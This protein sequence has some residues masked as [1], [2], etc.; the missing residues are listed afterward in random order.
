[1]SQP[2]TSFGLSSP[3][4]EFNPVDRWKKLLS[5][6]DLEAVE[7]LIGDVLVELGYPLTAQLNRLSR[8]RLNL[9]LTRVL[10][11]LR[12]DVKHWAKTRTR[13][14]EIWH[15]EVPILAPSSATLEVSP[16]NSA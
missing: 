11:H 5:T 8:N 14:N 3:E 9:S 13:S 1:V 6:Q 4:R 15:R 16:K 12:F 2:N 7:A 10:Y